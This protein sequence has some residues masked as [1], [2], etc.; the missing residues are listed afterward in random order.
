MQLPHRL[1]RYVL[2]D[3]V[4]QGGMAELFLARFQSELGA[5]RRLVVKLILPMY[6]ER[7]EFSEMLIKE[8]KL[9]A[10]LTHANV[11]QVLELG[12]EE[13]RLFIV[14][15]YVEGFD[16]AALLKRC[17]KEKV[18]LPPE[19]ALHIVTELLGGLDYAHRKKDEQ[20]RPLGIVHRDVSPSNVLLSFDGEVKLCDFGIARANDWAT[21][22]G[23][24]PSEAIKGK[25][26]YMSPEHARG[27]PIDGRADVFAAGIIL[28]ELLAGRK[29]YRSDA[30]DLI[31]QARAA[32]VP[33]LPSR[34]L[35]D[36]SRLQDIV[37]KALSPERGARYATAGEMQR[38]LRDW[39]AEAGLLANPI[40]LGEWLTEH[41]GAEL[42]EQRRA[43]EQAAKALDRIP[44][45]ARVLMTP[46]PPRITY[47]D[48]EPESLAPM[49]LSPPS[50][51]AAPAPTA[52][53]P[54]WAMLVMVA[55]AV[56]LVAWL[57]SR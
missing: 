6:A 4:G 12:R 23:E 43:R 45:K 8:A 49:D 13:G 28:W 54:R 30:G 47:K 42:L 52:K 34:G 1:S 36:E 10:T 55:A 41:F 7:A 26:G 20:G 2:F 51:V 38:D 14:M 56:G 48:E 39:A 25:A 22:K 19:F 27:E 37:K 24:E 3:R 57:L 17:S 35:P 32:N 53:R 33:E 5:D 18:P 16:L 29:L 44:L 11:V 15:D 50:N 46:E 9:A 21:E 31:A 40:K